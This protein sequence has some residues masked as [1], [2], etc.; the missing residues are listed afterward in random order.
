[1][2]LPSN[3]VL[4]FGLGRLLPPRPA[5]LKPGPVPSV[6]FPYFCH[7]PSVF[8]VGSPWSPGV[9]PVPFEYPV[10]PVPPW[11]GFLLLENKSF[12]FGFLSGAGLAVVFVFVV[13]VA[14]GFT[15]LSV[16][17]VFVGF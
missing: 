11:P 7:P 10:P 5:S 8:P 13:L 1:M 2:S 12:G 4:Q 9:L 14:L 17:V 3:C 16:G 6:P 15:G